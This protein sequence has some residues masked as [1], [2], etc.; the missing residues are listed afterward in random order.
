MYLSVYMHGVAIYCVHAQHARCTRVPPIMHAD[1]RSPYAVT[2]VTLHFHSAETLEPLLAAP[3]SHGATQGAAKTI[4]ADSNTERR[5]AELSNVR[6][7][8]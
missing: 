5:S 4:A 3:D 6:V 1:M 7:R 8:L 2:T